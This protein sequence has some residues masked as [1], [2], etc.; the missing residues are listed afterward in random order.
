MRDFNDDLLKN[1]FDEELKKQAAR[2]AVVLQAVVATVDRF[3]LKKFHLHKHKKDV[4]NFFEAE[5]EAVYQSEVARHYQQ[6]LLKS[7]RPFQSVPCIC[8]WETSW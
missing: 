7:A 4:E 2:F 1:P 8:P 6:R 5:G 3:G